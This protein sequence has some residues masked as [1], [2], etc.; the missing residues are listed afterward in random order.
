MTKKRLKQLILLSLLAG[1]FYG[2]LED[3]FEVEIPPKTDNFNIAEARSWFEAN[4]P[5]MMAGGFS[6]R[7]GSGEAI[8]P[9]PVFNWNLAELSRDSVWEVVEL[10]W[11]YEEIEQIFALGEVWRQAQAN[12]TVPDNVTRLVVIQHRETNE[13]FGFKM[14]IAPTLDYLLHRGDSLHANMYLHRDSC[15]SGIVMF[16]CLGGGFINGWLYQDGEITGEIVGKVELC[17][18]ITL[19]DWWNDDPSFSTLLSDFVVTG[20]RGSGG[21][22]TQ[23]SGLNIHLPGGQSNNPGGVDTD[24]SSERTNGGGSSSQN[25]DTSNETSEQSEPPQLGEIFNITEDNQERLEE[26][27]DAVLANCMGE[28]LLKALN[29]VMPGTHRLNIQFTNDQ[30]ASWSFSTSTITLWWDAR[31]DNFF[32]ELFHAFQ[33]YGETSGPNGTLGTVLNN[34]LLNLEM[35]AR[36]AQYMFLRNTRGFY[37]S[38][39]QRAWLMD[40]SRNTVMELTQFLDHRGRFLSGLSHWDIIRFDNRV[41][42]VVLPQLY[43]VPEHRKLNMRYDMSRIGIANFRK[44][45]SLTINCPE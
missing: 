20:T 38:A 16:Y 36:F 10:P 22:G 37:G 39:L 42:D 18:E 33:A 30:V 44:L 13:T 5:S 11:E 15:L 19:R 24:I 29:A 41:R 31:P 25:T 9:T 40:P 34:P 26:L 4:N 28:A 3:V 1:I 45:R 7:S 43:A 12:N 21:G 2:C 14:R 27:F 17:D 8:T 35:E 6:L 32:H 23:T